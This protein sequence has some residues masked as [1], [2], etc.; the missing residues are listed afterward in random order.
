M[1]FS[2]NQTTAVA[3][4]YVWLDH[5][6]IEKGAAITSLVG[7]FTHGYARTG[8]YRPLVALTISLDALAGA[9]AAFHFDSL[10]WHAL[11]A[12]A[13]FFAAKALLATERQALVAACLF[14]VHPVS[15]EIAED[16]K[17]VV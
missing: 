13:C 10:I 5:G 15:G 2:S 12:T 1:R 14:A 6:D 7:A 16:R 9:A 8:F 4:G 3:G 11:A 17:S